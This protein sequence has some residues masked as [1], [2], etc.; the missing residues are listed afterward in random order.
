M[1]ENTVIE[2]VKY[3]FTEDELKRL[4]EELVQTE[5]Q[6]AAWEEE[7]RLTDGTLNDSI[8]KGR[9]TTVSLARKISSGFE[10]REVEAIIALDTPTAGSK[11]Y[12]EVATGSIIRDA[13]MSVE[14]MRQA[15]LD[16]EQG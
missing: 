5:L 4:R 12:I 6:V 2:S 8:K 16:F 15:R 9:A 10:V 3:T 13:P 14:E 1:A 7:K 11:R